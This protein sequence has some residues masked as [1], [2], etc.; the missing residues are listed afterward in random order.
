LL[1]QLYPGQQCPPG[2]KSKET[3]FRILYTK[4]RNKIVFLSYFIEVIQR[5]PQASLIFVL[6]RL[7]KSKFYLFGWVN[8]QFYSL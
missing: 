4:A 6:R 3:H 1:F 7:A 8:T 5:K 2:A